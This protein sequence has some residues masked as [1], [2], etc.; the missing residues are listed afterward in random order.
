ME[1]QHLESSCKE[2]ATIN[3]RKLEADCK[4]PVCQVVTFWLTLV[5]LTCVFLCTY[6][7][8]LPT[9]LHA[10]PSGTISRAGQEVPAPEHPQPTASRKPR[11]GF[12]GC[13]CHLPAYLIPRGGDTR[14]LKPLPLSSSL[15]PGCALPGLYWGTQ[16]ALTPRPVPGNAQQTGGLSLHHAPALPPANTHSL[17][18]LLGLKRKPK[19]RLGNT[20]PPSSH[21][22]IP[23]LSPSA[24]TSGLGRWA[25]GKLTLPAARPSPQPPAPPARASPPAGP[26]G[27]AAAAA[28]SPVPSPG[29]GSAAP[30]PSAG[31]RPPA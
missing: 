31:T 12:Q 2:R 3:R 24:P 6:R 23:V 15:Y 8:R 1:L 30:R 5:S 9:H 11:P 21:P 14:S 7:S 4:A 22:D 26:A 25:G 20:A 16:Q 13:T 19:E 10:E 28:M 29:A 27:G 18:V 17:R